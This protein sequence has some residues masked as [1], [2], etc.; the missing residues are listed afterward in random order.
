MSRADTPKGASFGRQTSNKQ[1]APL[2]FAWIAENGSRAQRRAVV[3]K[4][5]SYA[6]QG[7]QD[8]A[9]ALAA[10]KRHGF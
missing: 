8:A 6:A 2:D 9:N 10:L 3:K 1:P 5:K 4:L 7:N